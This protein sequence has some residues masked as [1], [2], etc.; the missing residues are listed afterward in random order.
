[1]ADGLFVLL[2]DGLFSNHANK[3]KN[4]PRIER[5]LFLLASADL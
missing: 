4:P 5:A 1:V 2:S 3:E